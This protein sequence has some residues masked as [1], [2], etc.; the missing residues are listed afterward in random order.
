MKKPYTVLFG[1]M[2]CPPSVTLTLCDDIEEIEYIVR[3][4]VKPGT[5]A[6]ILPSQPEVSFVNSNFVNGKV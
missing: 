1:L 2:D 4:L 3:E 6:K 5:W